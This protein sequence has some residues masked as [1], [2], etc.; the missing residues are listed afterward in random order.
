MHKFLSCTV[1]KIRFFYHPCRTQSSFP[2]EGNGELQNARD[3]GGLQFSSVLPA[4]ICSRASLLGNYN[5]LFSNRITISGNAVASP[6]RRRRH[7][8]R[9]VCGRLRGETYP[10]VEKLASLP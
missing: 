10:S 6:F 1:K 3:P 8:S 7:L 2:P 4:S 5:I 9:K